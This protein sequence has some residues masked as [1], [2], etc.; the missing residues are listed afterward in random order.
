MFLI[1]LKFYIK[2]DVAATQY[3]Q[4]GGVVPKVIR[5]RQRGKRSIFTFFKSFAKFLSAN[6]YGHLVIPTSRPVYD[7]PIEKSVCLDKQ[8]P[9]VSL[10]DPDDLL[11]TLLSCHGG[12]V[13]YHGGGV[14]YLDP[15]I[16]IGSD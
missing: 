8:N 11:T 2:E 9:D 6:I 7:L 10:P 3:S 5:E 1:T 16:Y 13:T 15:I 4:M 12:G 14:F